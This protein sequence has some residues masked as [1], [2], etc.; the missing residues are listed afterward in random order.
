MGSSARPSVSVVIPVYNAAATIARALDSV[1]AQT[2]APLVEIIIVDDGS[3]DDTAQVVRTAYPMVTL[4]P[5]E[6][7]GNAGARNRGVAAATGEIITFLDADDEWLPGKLATQ[8]PQLQRLPDLSLLTCECRWMGAPRGTRPPVPKPSGVSE[9]PFRDLFARRRL[10]ACCSGWVLA[11]ET[12]AAVGG[13]D[14]QLRRSCDWEFLLRLAAQGGSVCSLGEALYNYYWTEN[15]V[16]RAPE[17][18]VDYA[19]IAVEVLARHDPDDSLAPGL[20]TEDEFQ[21][22]LRDAEAW[23]G[24]RL[25]RAGRR[26][27]AR[28]VLGRAA[29]RAR[30][31]GLESISC[32]WAARHPLLYRALGLFRP[33]LRPHY[34]PPSKPARPRR[35][36]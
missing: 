22:H 11:R 25:W 20:L 29:A 28:E 18:I 31:L 32:V 33:P 8:I 30:G 10:S 26:A 24:R 12:F 2:Y 15:S 23:Y 16:S 7:R 6:N 9:I 35:A 13:M 27:E 4:L 19:R 3:T 5:Q 14:G 17:A 21:A 34:V 36:A 1:L